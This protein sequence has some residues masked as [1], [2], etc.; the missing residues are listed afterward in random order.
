M[1]ISNC[2]RRRSSSA[3]AVAADSIRSRI[4]TDNSTVDNRRCMGLDWRRRK[5]LLPQILPHKPLGQLAQKAHAV[6][7]GSPPFFVVPLDED[8]LSILRVLPCDNLHK[9]GSSISLSRIS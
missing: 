5:Q 2:F 8:V 7:E 9:I 3:V 4:H 1:L 6:Y